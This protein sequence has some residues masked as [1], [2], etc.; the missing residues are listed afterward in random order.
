MGIICETNIVKKHAGHAGHQVTVCIL[1]HILGM[2]MFVVL[3][4]GLIPELV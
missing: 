2:E 1:C 4:Y 3:F